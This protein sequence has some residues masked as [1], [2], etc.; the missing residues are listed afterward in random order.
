MPTS[1]HAMVSPYWPDELSIMMVAPADRR[2]VANPARDLEAV[3]VRHV[4]VE[5]DERE[6]VGRSALASSSARSAAAPLSATVGRI[7]QR[8]SRSCRMRRLTSLSS[9][10]STRQIVQVD[11]PAAPARASLMPSR[12]VKW[13][14]LPSSGSLS[15]Q[16]RPPISSTSVDEIA[17]PR[18]VPPNWRVVEPSACLNGSK[19]ACCLSGGM[20]M[21]VSLTK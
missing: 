7:C 21:P 19:I 4:R 14:V 17:R 2:R 13:N 9:T 10:I 8:T 5:Q 6:R 15:T 12:A 16:I 11:A 1:R 20:P 3:H 18:P